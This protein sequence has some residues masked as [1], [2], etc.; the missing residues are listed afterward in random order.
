MN[1]C[2]Y[3]FKPLQ[4]WAWP[5]SA[6][7]ATTLKGHLTICYLDFFQVGEPEEGVWWNFL[8]VAFVWKEKLEWQHRW[9][10]LNFFGN[11]LTT[12]L[13]LFSLSIICLESENTPVTFL[14]K[15][16]ICLDRKILLYNA[17]YNDDDD[18]LKTNLWSPAS[19]WPFDWGLP[20]INEN[21]HWE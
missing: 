6:K 20:G 16:I 1:C 15:I 5:S 3:I 10:G 11:L 7:L 4:V 13:Q 14:C 19:D 8:E 21:K 9:F 18:I 2:T 12:T 17:D